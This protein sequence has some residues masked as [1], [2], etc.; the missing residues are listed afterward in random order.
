MC[1]CLFLYWVSC[2]IVVEFDS[3]VYIIWQIENESAFVVLFFNLAMLLN[4]S[5]HVQS[6]ATHEPFF[7]GA[8]THVPLI[9]VI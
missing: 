3:K 6:T 9:S 8:K 2:G 1:M 4:R 7:L 5:T